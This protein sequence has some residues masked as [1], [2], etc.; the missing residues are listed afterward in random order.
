MRKYRLIAAVLSA[1]LLLGLTACA[2]ETDP[3]SPVNFYY[4]RKNLT[5]YEDSVM[6]SECYDSAG[7]EDD[8]EFLL[9]AYLAGAVSQSSRSPFPSNLR[10]ISLRMEESTLIVTL[11][12]AFADL[13][14]LELNIACA[15]L[16]MTC[17]ELTGAESVQILTESALL[18]GHKSITI[19]ASQIL[20]TDDSAAAAASSVP[21][22]VTDMP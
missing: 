4:P 15:A 13:S 3:V 10:L 5:G 2:G 17:M 9:Q 6:F 21:P 18:N 14:G 12:D 19:N 7:H 16:S 20:L 8:L 1:V 11:S 22:D